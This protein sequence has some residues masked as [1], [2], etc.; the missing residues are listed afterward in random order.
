MAVKAAKT[1]DQAKTPI[2]ALSQGDFT[3]LLGCSTADQV[4]ESFWV[5]KTVVE[6]Q[7]KVDNGLACNENGGGNASFSLPERNKGGGRWLWLKPI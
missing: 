6:A 2:I 3:T 1:L 7:N 5:A 4:R